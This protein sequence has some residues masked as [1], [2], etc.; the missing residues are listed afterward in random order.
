MNCVG[1]AE[2]A[3]FILKGYGWR[4]IDGDINDVRIYAFG[5]LETIFHCHSRLIIA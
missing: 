1:L 2:A 4:L 3:A 5:M